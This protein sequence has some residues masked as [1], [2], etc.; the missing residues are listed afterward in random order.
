VV[1][2]L[3][4][5]RVE[6]SVPLADAVYQPGLPL[7][8]H[9]PLDF[10]YKAT[11]AQTIDVVRPQQV[12]PV[13]LP[14]NLARMRQDIRRVLMLDPSKWELAVDDD[15][16]L[17]DAAWNLTAMI[18]LGAPIVGDAVLVWRPDPKFGAAGS[19]PNQGERERAKAAGR[20]ARA[21]VRARA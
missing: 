11:R 7:L 15:G 10:Y 2:F 14:E 17:K 19:R 8:D 12:V 16:R 20:A 4:R 6:D 18:L 5:E 1:A 21:R 3:L 9:F 13:P